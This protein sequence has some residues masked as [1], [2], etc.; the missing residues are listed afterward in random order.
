MKMKSGGTICLHLLIGL[1]SWITKENKEG[2]CSMA[3]DLQRPHSLPFP[4]FRFYYNYFITK[5]ELN[6][7]YD[8]PC[9]IMLSRASFVFWKRANGIDRF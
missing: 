8:G 7:N 3:P 4:V 9:I 5:V 1:Q 6:I 2:D